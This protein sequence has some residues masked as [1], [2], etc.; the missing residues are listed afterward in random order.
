MSNDNFKKTLETIFK[1][2]EK[3]DNICSDIYRNIEQTNMDVVKV[4]E[5]YIQ[6]KKNLDKL[7][8]LYNSFLK[9]QE[10]ISNSNQHIREIYGENINIKNINEI[11]EN[12]LLKILRNIK[13]EEDKLL[14]YKGVK[15]VDSLLGK[16]N[17]IK[18]N[19]IEKIL[20]VYFE[21]LMNK[22]TDEEKMK[23]I[24]LFLMEFTDQKMFLGKYSNSIF[25]KISYEDIGTDKKLLLER[26]NYIEEDFKKLT[27][28]M[29][30]SWVILML[31][32]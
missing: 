29:K 10:T 18:N 19:V 8:N 3:I 2:S 28:T 5:P 21:N 20:P 13:E 26:T 23:E 25:D 32:S 15:I 16:S 22:E 12:N 9:A 17:L 4:F 6:P 11:L 27:N 31:R 7:Y 1:I 30:G 24:S 14:E